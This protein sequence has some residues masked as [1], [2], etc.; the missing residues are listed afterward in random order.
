MIFLN[1][2]LEGVALHL[3]IREKWADM[4]GGVNKMFKWPE[5]LNKKPVR[6]ST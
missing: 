2:M 6:D 5:Y 4:I 1:S 3:W